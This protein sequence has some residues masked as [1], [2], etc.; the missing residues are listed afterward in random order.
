M[1]PREWTK[2]DD[3][4]KQVNQIALT[5]ATECEKVKNLE[6]LLSELWK[7]F[8]DLQNKIND[9]EKRLAIIMAFGAIFQTIAISI[10][11][12]FIS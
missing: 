5:V 10:V 3:I 12:K 7:K 6:S 2:T 1:A 8:E 4:E 11:I 9:V